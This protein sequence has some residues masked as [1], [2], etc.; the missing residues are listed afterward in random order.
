MM[1]HSSNW[2][3]NSTEISHTALKTNNAAAHAVDKVKSAVPKSGKNSSSERSLIL[4]TGGTG[5]VAT[6]VINAFLSNGYS[7]RTT[8]RDASKGDDVKNTH[9]GHAER[10]EIAIVD[11]ITKP[12]AFD[13]AVKG[14]DGV[15]HT[16]SPFVLNFKDNERDLLHPAIEGTKSVLASIAKNAPQV[17]RVVITSSFAAILDPKQGARPGYTYSEK[18]WNPTTYEEAKTGDGTIAYTASKTFAEKAALDFVNEHRPNFTVAAINPPMIYGPLAQKVDIDHLNTS[19]ADV[20]R[21]LDG[22]LDKQVPETGFPAFADKNERYFIVGGTFTNADIASSLRK[23][24]PNKSSKIPDPGNAKSFEHFQ[25]DNSKSKNELHIS[26]IPIEQCIAD[27][28]KSLLQVE[29]ASQKGSKYGGQEW[30]R[31]V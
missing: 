21:F 13:E 26:Y 16:A 5:F 11:D 20:W 9:S 19:S 12:G 30:F 7:V 23:A 17:E 15:V 1:P 24:F 4:I 27:T 25:V 6:W 8:V 28:G 31:H 14:V 18:D 22:S 29:E 2:L 3:R 10:L